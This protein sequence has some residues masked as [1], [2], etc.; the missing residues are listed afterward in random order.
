M[1]LGAPEAKDGY[2]L[3]PLTLPSDG[4][5]TVTGTIAVPSRPGKKPAS[6]ADG[7]P[8]D[9]LASP[10]QP[11]TTVAP[12]RLFGEV[13]RLA[14]AGVVVMTIES[15]ADATQHRELKSPYLGLFNLLSLRAF[16]VGRGS[17]VITTTP[18]FARRSTSPVRR[19]GRSGRGRLAGRGEVGQR[20]V[21]QQRSPASCRAGSG[22]Q[23]SRHSRRPVARE[24]QRRELIA[25][26]RLRCAERHRD[27][28]RAGHTRRAGERGGCRWP[29]WSAAASR[30]PLLAMVAG[31][32]ATLA[33][34]VRVSD[35]TVSPWNV[36]ATWP[37]GRDDHVRWTLRPEEA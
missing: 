28:R 5:T 37:V 6:A 10:G 27:A 32:A 23:S 7:Q 19:R 12:R 4:T 18:A 34:R 29:A 30:Q 20:A 15:A 8:A 17:I 25:V 36:V 13:E 9:R 22:L 14:K 35:A 24:A 26:L 21:H 11:A 1:T 3:A 31:A 33:A 16:L 2:Q